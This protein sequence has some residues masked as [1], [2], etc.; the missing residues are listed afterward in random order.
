MPDSRCHCLLPCTPCAG[1][2][3]GKLPH[4]PPSPAAADAANL[5]VLRACELEADLNSM[6]Q[7]DATL[8]AASGDNL[9][10]GQQARLSLA[11]TLYTHADIYALDDV[12]APLDRQVASALLHSLLY[13]PLLEGKTLILATGNPAAVAAADLVVQLLDGTVAACTAASVPSA[14]RAA[15]APAGMASI[16]ARAASAATGGSSRALFERGWLPGQASFCT[17][18]SLWTGSEAQVALAADGDGP[19]TP[20]SG[21]FASTARAPSALD[22]TSNTFLAAHTSTP[23]LGQ[24]NDA[25]QARSSAGGSDAVRAFRDL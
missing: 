18:D 7:G 9:S 10:G 3:G 2:L 12:L 5:Q 11:R 20:R 1:A 23:S 15:T 16:F 25:A 8:V 19:A 4:Q 22:Q 21:R 14:G 24:P 17:E 13:S 6:P